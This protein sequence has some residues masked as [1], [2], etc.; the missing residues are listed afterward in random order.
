MIQPPKLAQRLMK[1]R[2]GKA[3]VEDI[4]G[5]LDEVY[6]DRLDESGKRKADLIY[7]QMIFSLLFSYGIQKRKSRAAYSSYYFTNYFDMYRNYFKIAI[8]NFSKHRLFT[9]LNITGLALGMCICLLALTIFVAIYR[10]DEFHV[11]KDRIYQLNTSLGDDSGSRT[12]GS[13]FHPISG[14]LKH[15]YP[16]VEETLDIQD[17][18]N[19]KINHFG[20]EI[21]IYGH[22]AN[23]SF[24][25]L[26][27]FQMIEG[28]RT[29]ALDKPF[30]I[31]LTQKMAQKLFRDASPIGK[32]LETELGTFTVSGVMEDLKQTHFF[33]EVLVSYGTL[34]KVQ[35]YDWGNDWTA[36][37]DHYVYVMLSS[38][39]DRQALDD[40]L[41]NLSD[42]AALFHE[43][44]EVRIESIGLTNVVPRWNISNALGI[45][46]DQPSMIFFFSIGLLVLLPAV[47]NYTNLS[48][49]RALK[50]AKE[51]GI[52]K[53][54]GAE[55][56]Q[57][58]TQFIIETIVL[59]LLAL[60]G[61]FILMIPLKREFLSMVRAASVLDTSPGVY[62]VVTFVIFS[63]FVGFFAGIFPAQYF[64]RLNPMQTLKG[65]IK[66]GRN[67]VSTLKKG[68]FVFQFFLSLVF[69][70][71]V[72]ALG[73]QYR[74]VLNEKHGF[75][76]ENVLV[77]PFRGIDKQ[78]TFNELSKHPSVKSI[79]TASGLPGVGVSHVVEAT[80]N[81][82][83]TINVK[84]VYVG[85]D[86]IQQ[87]DMKLVWGNDDLI[88]Q[89]N[90]TEEL[91]LVNEQF[92]KAIAVFNV[93]KDSLRFTF[94][95][96]TH[97]RVAG[98]LE[99]FNY[100][101]LSELIQPLV[102]RYSID[103]GQYALLSVSSSDMNKTI[104]ELETIWHGI[105]T[106]QVFEANFLDDEIEE[107][108]YFLR[109]QLKFFSVL[110]TLAITISCLGLL[111]M[112][113]FST[114]NRTKEIAIRKIMG[115][116]SG[117]LFYLL[118]RDFI[119]LI[120]LSALIAIP[121]SYV[122]YDK[123]FLYFLIRYGTGLGVLEIVASLVF[124]AMVG[125]VSIYSQTAKITKGNPATRLRYE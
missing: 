59:S 104:T 124:L 100:E 11:N 118:S 63:L 92:L 33:F 60:V 75:D 114:E 64:S 93:Q 45:G 68:L 48:I 50:R 82:L 39:S 38:E 40:A 96:G 121:F 70:I 14:Q 17:E 115:A 108:Y 34:E 54:A 98:I 120:G 65:E 32:T 81:D 62:Q 18:F 5:D 15:N 28:D 97:C 30:N 2:V 107:A 61:A 8:R 78:V 41:L 52:R 66:N 94:A 90:Q 74:Y 113:T 111:G 22:F 69:I 4:L 84:Q 77:I 85:D 16:F 42:E 103:Q 23:S 89:P 29:S 36:Y 35:D 112:V 27:D 110:S 9:I 76:S 10:S 71:G 87:M 37:R 44:L 57:I 21:P 47:F 25:K 6:F 122:F 79:T 105:D 24:F 19:A 12:F 106:E 58:K 3:D 125:M 51:I 26:F 99:D 55:K 119:K 117:T 80:S 83:D 53:V 101:P 123:L 91:V 67:Q 88:D 31:V 46:W 102:F 13:T 56:T 109:V 7:W 1:W 20:N 73:R 116:S 49:A 72:T 43:G 95:D 86:F